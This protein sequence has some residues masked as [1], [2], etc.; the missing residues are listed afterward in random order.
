[1]ISSLLLNILLAVWYSRPTAADTRAVQ[2][3]TQTN[4]Q[5]DILASNVE[6]LPFTSILYMG[7]GTDPNVDPPITIRIVES[8]D[9]GNATASGNSTADWTEPQLTVIEHEQNF[10]MPPALNMPPGVAWH[11]SDLIIVNSKNISNRAMMSTYGTGLVA[12]TW[13]L[14]ALT[15][16]GKYQLGV[17]DE[18]VLFKAM[19]TELGVNDPAV[20]AFSN[21]VEQARRY[22]VT[23]QPGGETVSESAP[24]LTGKKFV[25]TSTDG[26]GSKV[27]DFDF[28]KSISIG[29]GDFVE[30]FANIKYK[31]TALGKGLPSM[32]TAN[33]VM[34]RTQSLQITDDPASFKGVQ[35]ISL[36][37]SQSAPEL[38][39]LGSDGAGREGLVTEIS[40]AAAALGYAAIIAGTVFCILELMAG[41]YLVGAMGIVAA[42]LAIATT[43][44]TAALAGAEGGPIG[45]MLGTAIGI[46]FSILPGLFKPIVKPP[47]VTN[48]TQIVQFKMFGQANHTGNEKCRETNPNCV[49]SY[50]PGILALSFGWEYYDAVV[51]MIYANQGFPINIPDIATALGTATSFDK[52][53]NISA[54]ATVSCGN[55]IG[56]HLVPNRWGTTSWSGYDPSLCN[57]P[58]M[59][60]NRDSYVLPNINKTAA[61]VHDMIIP[62]PGGT[63]KLIDNADNYVAIP[64]YGIHLR[65]LPVSV[66][67]GIDTFNQ[68][69]V[70]GSPQPPAGM[71]VGNATT[72]IPSDVSNADAGPSALANAT[73]IPT[74]TGGGVVPTQSNSSNTSSDTTDVSPT[75]YLQRPGDPSP[76]STQQSTSSRPTPSGGLPLDTLP[77]GSSPGNLSTDSRAGS[78]YTP[79]PP[80]NGFQASLTP[81]NS[82]CFQTNDGHPDTCFPN[83][84]YTA[85][86]GTFRFKTANVKGLKMAPGGTLVVTWHGTENLNTAYVSWTDT[87]T[88][89]TTDS[90][91]TRAIHSVV[92]F[93]VLISSP[94]P[95]PVA[96]LFTYPQYEGDCVC[97]GLGG[98]NMTDGLGTVQ[99]LGVFGGATVTLFPNQ[100]GDPGSQ[101][102][103]VSQPDLT[104]APYG[105][106]SN[107][108]KR[109]AALAVQ[110]TSYGVVTKRG[111][112]VR[113]ERPRAEW[114]GMTGFGEKLM[115]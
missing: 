34:R 74:S 112:I 47:L 100:Y 105:T 101:K 94:D 67:C 107:L 8:Q 98:G 40:M 114:V 81:A 45:I 25:M 12:D 36:P 51:F 83:G 66:A 7:P 6:N 24:K 2:I 11:A 89:D 93:E 103:S 19:F 80:P 29:P 54:I 104:T 41:S 85:Q 113:R 111:R 20:D 76:T 92:S 31:G 52:D 9:D 109:V 35:P 13:G 64:N 86:L 87:F 10:T 55:Y 27:W 91:L 23:T 3:I 33:T 49:A 5:S 88:Q 39:E 22:Y 63:C 38:T 57:N 102:F 71:T 110:D 95:P 115:G 58:V 90:K 69:I 14:A 44:I 28:T 37:K 53:R 42:P 43:I 108:N 32:R 60:F 70:Q 77:A 96:C 26:F 46:L 78:G 62:A 50:G 18:N 1:M 79:P 73:G 59:F 97:V 68:S 56:S 82:A 72:P 30:G 84:T 61:E 99:S 4:I 15:S 48:T 21:Q 17:A 65:G 75:Q 106:N 16:D